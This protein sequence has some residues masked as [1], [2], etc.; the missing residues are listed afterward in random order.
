[1]SNQTLN[2]FIVEEDVE[3]ALKL[4]HFLETR[5]GTVFNIFT[6]H[7]PA[8]A[9]AKVDKDTSVVVLDYDYF[10]ARGNEIINS[11]KRINQKTQVIIL[12]N[13]EEISGVIDTYAKKGDYY[14]HKGKRVK[15]KLSTT[16]LEIITYPANYLQMKY[17]IGQFFI[18]LIF[19]FVVVGIL[20]FI[21]MMMIY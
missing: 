17:S 9:L 14:F 15:K 19:L 2:L 7:N 11:I 18:Y 16:I 20:V 21:G 1:M 10:G 6:F 12:S 13:Y 8:T 5:F 3:N 4:H